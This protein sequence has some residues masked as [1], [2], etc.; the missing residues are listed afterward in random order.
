[1][2][3]EWINGFGEN[4]EEEVKAILHEKKQQV[5]VVHHRGEWKV[6]EIHGMHYTGQTAVYIGAQIGG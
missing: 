3:I 6:I 5:A 2:R 4:M 1:M